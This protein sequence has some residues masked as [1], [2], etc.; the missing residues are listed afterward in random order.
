MKASDV[1]LGVEY[2]ETGPLAYGNEP[3]INPW[4][5]RFT[6]LPRPGW[7]WLYTMAAGETKTQRRRKGDELQTRWQQIRREIVNINDSSIARN[8]AVASTYGLPKIAEA[9]TVGYVWEPAKGHYPAERWMHDR[10]AWVPGLV[11]T[12][13]IHRTWAEWEEQLRA[14]QEI[15]R[16]Q[17][18]G[19]APHA[20]QSALRELVKYAAMIGKTPAEVQADLLEA[21]ANKAASHG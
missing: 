13:S 7:G 1:V 20:Y 12:A 2:C 19:R 17:E 10:D 3:S 4:K 15:R 9:G 6:E 16:Q 5:V 14:R 8:Q 18:L 21:L 11:Q